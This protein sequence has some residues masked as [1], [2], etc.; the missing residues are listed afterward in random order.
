VTLD[1]LALVFDTHRAQIT[2]C[3]GM[4]GRQILTRTILVPILDAKTIPAMKAMK[5]EDE[6]PLIYRLMTTVG[7]DAFVAQFYIDFYEEYETSL[8]QYRDDEAWAVANGEEGVTVKAGVELPMT[9][10]CAPPRYAPPKGHP[11]ATE[12]GG[13]C[14]VS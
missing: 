5:R 9:E 1:S 13:Y 12:N 7:C 2:R 10:K 14:C 3:N 6:R 11:K 8:Q 4:S